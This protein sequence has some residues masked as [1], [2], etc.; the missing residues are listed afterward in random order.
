M[1]LERSIDK[2]RVRQAFSRQAQVYEKKASLQKEVAKKLVSLVSPRSTIHDSRFMVL[3]IGIGT[4][5]ATREFL[6]RFPDAG[7]F[8]CDIADG[9]LT[10]ADKTG[11]TL[12]GADAE[13]LPFKNNTFDMIFSSLAF[14]WTNLYDS[15][16]EA[17]RVLRPQGRFYFSTFGERTLGELADSYTS[18]LRMMNGGRAAGTMK[19]EASGKIMNVMESAGFK[20]IKVETDIISDS[21]P[22]PEALLR[23]LKDIGAGN[24]SREFHPSRT[25][26]NET[27]KVYRE[28]YGKEGSISATFEIVY[29]QGV[30]G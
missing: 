1:N 27:F 26:L 24:P 10:E 14:Q 12:T 11:A 15:I 13:E 25:L 16:N 20:D 9:M 21:Y 5:F 4:G 8:G 18:A 29:A 6:T 2:S 19:F 7:I 28:K 22:T 17:F 23:S 3:D 30:K